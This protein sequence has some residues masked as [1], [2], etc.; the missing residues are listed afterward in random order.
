MF[1]VGG[2]QQPVVQVDQLTSASGSDVFTKRVFL[3]L[4]YHH[5][6]SNM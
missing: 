3:L 2:L 4:S 5:V 6:V 1:G